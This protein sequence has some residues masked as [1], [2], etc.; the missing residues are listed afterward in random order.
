MSYPP[1]PEQEVA[2][3]LA[4]TGQTMKLLAFAGAGKTSTLVSVA[5]ALGKLGKKGIYLAF[6][7]DIADEA[8]KKMP[9]NVRAKTFHSMALS[10]APSYIKQR[11]SQEFPIW[12]FIKRFKVEDIM[13]NAFVEEVDFSEESA[14]KSKSKQT[15][16]LNPNRQKT[17]VDGCLVKFYLDDCDKPEFEHMQAS[18]NEN[19]DLSESDVKALADELLP[20]AR[21]MWRDFCDEKGTIGLSGRHDVYL[22]LWAMSKP[23]LDTDFILFD[24]AQDADPIMTRVLTTQKCQ[25][26]YVGDPYQQIYSFRGAVNVMQTLDVPQSELTQ[27]FRFG[28]ELA[29]ACQPILDALGCKNKIRGLLDK[30]TKVHHFMEG[31]TDHKIDAY[32][33]RNNASAVSLAIDSVVKMHEKG[34]EDTS[35][36]ILPLNLPLKDTKQMMFD[37]SKVNKGNCDNPKLKGFT[38][39]KELFKYS[40]DCPT[41]TEISPFVRLYMQ[42]GMSE[43]LDAISVL[44][45]INPSEHKGSVVTTSHRSKGLEWDN[46]VLLDDLAEVWPEYF[47]STDELDVDELRLLY[48]AITRAKKNIWLGKVTGFMDTLRLVL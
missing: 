9:K 16:I 25:V 19:L 43:V 48:V 37:I 29:Q 24:E 34:D 45:K 28:D 7:K 36:V 12:D 22:K 10:Q 26:I 32:L 14:S 44:E 20:I 8:N 23:Q 38:S 1:T 21:D 30:P 27:S 33:S 46:V 17:I 18:I 4:C 31:V 11:L 39:F 6:N 3:N 35:N 5:N 47:D 2:I 13:L 15:I 42:F 41:D 40:K